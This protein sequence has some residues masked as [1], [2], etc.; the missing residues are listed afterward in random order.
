MGCEMVMHDHRIRKIRD[1]VVIRAQSITESSGRADF[2]FIMPL[3][4]RHAG[5]CTTPFTPTTAL[6]HVEIEY[7]TARA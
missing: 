2:A 1:R 6:P 4:Q 7:V 5:C 3:V